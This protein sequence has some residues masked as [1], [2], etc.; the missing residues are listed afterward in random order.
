MLNKSLRDMLNIVFCGIFDFYED[1][2]H[3]FIIRT[4]TVCIYEILF[5]KIRSIGVRW[6]TFAPGFQQ[7]EGRVPSPDVTKKIGRI[8]AEQT[9]ST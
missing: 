6:T 1:N 4:S 7:C 9:G 2:K 3:T 5:C 8:S